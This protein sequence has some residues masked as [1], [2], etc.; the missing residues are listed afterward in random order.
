MEGQQSK[1]ME[2]KKKKGKEDEWCGVRMRDKAKRKG[3]KGG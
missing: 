1:E 2:K 3:K